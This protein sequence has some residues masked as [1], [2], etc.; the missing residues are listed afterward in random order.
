MTQNASQFIAIWQTSVSSANHEHLAMGIALLPPEHRAY[1]LKYHF[2]SD[3]LLHLAGRL[4]VRRYMQ[5]AGTPLNWDQWQWSQHGKPFLTKGPNF[6]ISQSDNLVVVAFSSHPVGIDVE[7]TKPLDLQSLTSYFHCQE[8]D[9]IRVAADQTSAFFR[10]WTRKEALLKAIGIGITEDLGSHNCVEPL[11]ESELTWH[12]HS[13][14]SDPTYF[15]ALATPLTGVDTQITQ[16]P[17]S[18]LLCE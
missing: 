11:V 7:S 6:N 9:F 15:M 10:I 8:Q 12:L 17:F 2:L 13:M 16:I 14:A 18:L 3:Q 5:R 1:V 4:L